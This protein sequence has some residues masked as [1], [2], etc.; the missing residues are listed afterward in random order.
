MPTISAEEAVKRGLAF[1]NGK[2]QFADGRRMGLIDQKNPNAVAVSDP[3]WKDLL[4]IGAV[5]GGFAAPGLLA[6]TAATGG[7]TAA[8]AG[9]TAAGTAAAVPA[10]AATVG[11]IGAGTSLAVGLA[12]LG[13]DAITTFYGMKQQNKAL[14]LQAQSQKDQTAASLEAAKLNA[15]TQE[16]IAGGANDVERAKIAS[17]EKMSGETNALTREQFQLSAQ[18]AREQLAAEA[19]RLAARDARMA[20]FFQAM[21][22]GLLGGN[23]GEAAAMP[24]GGGGGGM[25][26]AQGGAPAAAAPIEGLPTDGTPVDAGAP[27]R[28]MAS[29]NASTLAPA[30]QPGRRTLAD[31]TQQMGA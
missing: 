28:T 26:P 13:L 30:V 18:L 4:K 17:Q 14:E 2:W 7:G 12:G 22:T 3:V 16:R 8:A 25:A 15:A 21:A 29:L 9:T 1:V 5:A 31:F 23:G 20:P 19:Q 10:A 6:G 24:T 27:P 11:G